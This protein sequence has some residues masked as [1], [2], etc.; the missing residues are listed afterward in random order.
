M[1]NSYLY[2]K[3]A[4]FKVPVSAMRYWTSLNVKDL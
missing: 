2:A 3:G 4:N 1:E